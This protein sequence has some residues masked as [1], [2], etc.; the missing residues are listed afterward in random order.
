MTGRDDDGPKAV[1]RLKRWAIAQKC[2]IVEE[3]FVPGASVAMTARRNNVNANQVFG[4]RKKYRQGTLLDRKAFAR[5]ALPAPDPA[6]SAG[7]ALLRIGVVNHDGG[8]CPLPM[9]A[10]HS[11][12]PS[13]EADNV[14]GL[15]ESRRS[16]PGL[17]E[18]ELRGGIKLRV[19]AGIDEAALR[20]VLAVLKDVA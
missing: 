4:W 10:G 7:Q 12:P 6:T 15:P 19:D 20:R 5:T 16:V 8:I 18:I 2:R 9:A 14:T 17:I 11:A 13:R 3:T 1:R